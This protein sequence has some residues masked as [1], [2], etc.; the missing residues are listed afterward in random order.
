MLVEVFPSREQV[1]SPGGAKLEA[2]FVVDSL[3]FSGLNRPDIR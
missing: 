2:G 3:Y 1:K